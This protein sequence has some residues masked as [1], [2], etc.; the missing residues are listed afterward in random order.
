MSFSTPHYIYPGQSEIIRI[1]VMGSVCNSPVT[2][3]LHSTMAIGSSALYQIS[4]RQNANFAD[5]F[6]QI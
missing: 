4:V 6:L 5:G 2:D 1:F 3:Y